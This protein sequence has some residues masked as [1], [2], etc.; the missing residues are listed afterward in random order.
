MCLLNRGN[1]NIIETGTVSYR[2]TQTQ[3]A[4]ASQQA[5]N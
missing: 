3:A 1:S 4:K 5:P 2:Y